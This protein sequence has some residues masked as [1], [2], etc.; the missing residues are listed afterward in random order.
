MKKQYRIPKY[1]D[2]GTIGGLATMGIQVV[3]GLARRQKEKKIQAQLREQ[4]NNQYINSML[5]EDNAILDD[6]PTNGLNNYGHYMANGGNIGDPPIKKNNMFI[7]PPVKKDNIFINT[8][9]YRSKKNVGLPR[10]KE[11]TKSFINFVKPDYDRIIN[12]LDKGNNRYYLENS[13]PLKIYQD[14][15]NNPNSYIIKD[16]YALPGKEYAMANGGNLSLSP[17]HDTI[18]GSLIPMASGM[19]KAVGNTHEES[20]IDGT[21][22][23]K[24][25]AN[26][27]PQAEVEDEEMIKDGQMV[28]SDRLKFDKKNTYAQKAETFARKRNKLEKQLSETH[29]RRSKNSIE[30][31]IVKLDNKENALFEHQEIKKLEKGIDQPIDKFNMGGNTAIAGFL[32][33]LN[34]G[35][36]INAINKGTVLAKMRQKAPLNNVFGEAVETGMRHLHD[37]TFNLGKRKENEAIKEED[38]ISETIKPQGVQTNTNIGLDPNTTININEMEAELAKYGTTGTQTGMRYGGK[39]KLRKGGIIPKA[40]DGMYRDFTKF[41]PKDN[42]NYP[43]DNY[44][45]NPK[46]GQMELDHA[47]ILGN[48]NRKLSKSKYFQKPSTLV[49]GESAGVPND[50]KFNYTKLVPYA[51]NL[52]NAFLTSRTPNVRKPNLQRS[53]RLNTAYN[54]NPQ[55]G[56]V[57]DAVASTTNDIISN[58]SSSNVA[59]NEL[60]KVRLAGMRETNALL[61]NKENIENQLKNQQVLNNQQIDAS[62]LAKMDRHNEAQT[63]RELGIQSAISRNVTNAVEDY[64][65]QEKEENM[66]RYQA[67]Q[68]LIEAKKYNSGIGI[69]TIL[70]NP[71]VVEELRNNPQDLQYYKD[72]ALAKDTNG[73]Y[74][75]QYAA[76]LFL[77]QFPEFKEEQ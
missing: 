75:N 26:G 62:N 48:S 13:E 20:S 6:Y 43:D 52:V 72:M 1:L 60:A 34:Q 37:G 21:S 2:G 35:K 22:G 66:R 51:D 33:T 24:L 53:G 25:L 29:D 31:N 74:I 3:G 49:E 56:A 46:T 38:M 32:E 47:Y 69:E 17:V 57:R 76:N 65:S 27:E 77:Q 8:P 45:Y 7:D 63:M 40:K 54:V 4:M 68:L 19:D 15:L 42:S 9:T 14:Y 50:K 36:R 23:I 41:L 58:T 59:R 30:R 10:K 16:D 64:R 11:L 5:A 39:V 18:G 73:N 70:E 44:Y 71:Y 28:F 67:Q 12:N 61:A 55:I